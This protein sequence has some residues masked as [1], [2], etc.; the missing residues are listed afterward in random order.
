MKKLRIALAGCRGKIEVFAD[1]INGTPESETV[2][3]WDNMPGRGEATAHRM[4]I[5]FEPD[6]DRLVTQYALDGV[7]ITAENAL[8]CELTEKAAR[9]GVSVFLEKPLCTSEQEAEQMRT[10]IR[11]SGVKFFLSDPFVRRGTME[12]KR[13]IQGGTLGKIT[14]ATFRLGTGAAI[15]GRVNYDYARNQGGIMADVGAH[16]LHKAHF[17]FGLPE[18]LASNLFYY[19][20]KAKQEQIEEKA[21]VA[22][23][24]PN[25]NSVSIECSWL[26]GSGG[27]LELVYGTKGWARVYQAGSTP[28]EEVVELHIAGEEPVTLGEDRLPL[29]P[30]RHILYFVEMLAHDLPNDIVGVDPRSNSG[31]SIDHAVEQTSMIAAIYRNAGKGMLPL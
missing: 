6:F 28:N 23:E 3:L 19:S 31:V 2:A 7:V 21:L 10:A 17:L 4:G 14:G 12:L 18:R 24:Y 11:E 15:Q 8:H 16:M 13:L 27:N 22:M 20:E 1:L 25:G 26:C 9:A 29:N 5:P 30:T